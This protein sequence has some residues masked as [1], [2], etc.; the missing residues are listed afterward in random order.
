MVLGGWDWEA[1]SVANSEGRGEGRAGERAGRREGGRELARTRSS[2][3]GRGAGRAA[4]ALRGAWGHVDRRGLQRC[5]GCRGCWW[6]K[7]QSW[8]AGVQG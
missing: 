5:S 4:G 2:L 7:G 8:G 3:R 1:P 6:M